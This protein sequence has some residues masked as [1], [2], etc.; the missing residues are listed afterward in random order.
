MALVRLLKRAVRRIRSNR[1]HAPEI[2][3]DWVELGSDYGGWP[4]IPSRLPERPL[5]YSFGVGDDISFDLAMIGR[6]SAQVHA[7]DPT[8]RSQRWVAGQTLPETFHFH[9]LGIGGRDG[10]AEFFPPVEDGHVS[11]SNAPSAAQTGTPVSAEILSLGTIMARRGH[12]RIDVLKMDI[13]G[14]EYEVIED[15]AKGDIRPGHVLV[16]FHHG[17]YRSTDR[18]TLDAVSTL[19]AAGYRL[20]FVSDTGREYGFIRQQ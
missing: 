8:P 12:D 11:F 4:V 2:R 18:D 17:M 6:Y 14:F 1:L 3:A 16:E 20:F 9:S 7:F 5:V 19:R 10:T 15:I 13:E